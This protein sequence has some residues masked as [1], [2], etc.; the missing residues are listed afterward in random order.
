MKFRFFS[1]AKLSK[2]HLLQISLIVLVSFIVRL[3]RIDYPLLDWHSFRQ[4]DTAS[5]TLRY[6]QEGID[7]L[8][9]KYHDLSN[10]QSGQDNPKGYRMTEFPLING[11]IAVFLRA[12]PQLDLVQF[13]RFISI[14]FSLGTLVTLYWLVKQIANHQLALLSAVFFGLLPYS[15]YYSRVILPE[16]FML[17]FVTASMAFWVAFLKDKKLLFW[18]L[19]WILLALSLLLKPFTAFLGPVFLSLLISYD[20]HF[21]KKP[22]SYL[23]PVLVFIPLFLWRHWIQQ[24][25]EGIPASDWLYNANQIRLRPAWF[26]WL[27]WERLTKLMAGFTGV[28]FG[29]SNLFKRD[30]LFY[31]LISWWLGI[32]IFFIVIATGNVQHDYY[33]VLILPCLSLTL[34]RGVLLF[35]KHAIKF[36]AKKTRQA[37]KLSLILVTALSFSIFLL[38]WLQVK[39]FFNVNQW[40]YHKA[41]IEA[42]LLLPKNAKVIAP[43][44]GDTMFLFQ[45][46]RNGWPI[47]GEINHKIQLGATHYITTNF[48]QEMHELEANYNTVKKTSEYIIIDL[49]TPKK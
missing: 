39:G 46:Q 45:T 48:D 13:S 9:P 43:A 8:R 33:Q 16:P 30:K 44:M 49:T 35:Y 2:N 25:P 21:Y 6:T 24:F 42:N 17:F 19:S 28:I 40:E 3:Y 18:W 41:G 20:K 37:K 36:L 1:L 12:L 29:F 47:G 11:L 38:S 23:F 7:L 15:I 27:F 5:V 14:V 22:T 32:L 34:A 31:I 4:A 10:I 26:R